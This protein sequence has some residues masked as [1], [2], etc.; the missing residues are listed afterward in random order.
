MQS[1]A[2]HISGSHDYNNEYGGADSFMKT[3]KWDAILPE[4]DSYAE[5]AFGRVLNRLLC[6]GD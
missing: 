1:V 4:W 3:R 5:S 6:S 2:S